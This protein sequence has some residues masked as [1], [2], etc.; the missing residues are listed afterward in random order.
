[1]KHIKLWLLALILL[2]FTA[3]SLGAADAKPQTVCP[4]LGGKINQQIYADYKG[5]RIYFCCQGCDKEFKKDPDKYLK[6]MEEQGVTL[7]PV[8]G[9]PATK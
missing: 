3:G 5:K 9:G 4:V 2:A 1:M 8:P 6:K 7:E